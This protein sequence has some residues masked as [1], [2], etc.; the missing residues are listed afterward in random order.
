[1]TPD[2]IQKS[3]VH[4]NAAQ[5]LRSARLLATRPLLAITMVLVGGLTFGAL[6]YLLKSSDALLAWDMTVAK[7][8]RAAQ[9]N[10]PWNVMENVLFGIYVG[11]Q[12]VILIGAILALYFL[13]K[14]FWRELAMLAIGLGGGGSLWFLLSHSF[15]RPG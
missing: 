13:H 4:S 10:A 14:R 5:G 2:R 15:N 6:A 9:V 8:F 12:V 3:S 7:M 11:R 1:M